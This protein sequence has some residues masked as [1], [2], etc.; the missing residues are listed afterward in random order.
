MAVDAAKASP[1]A[2]EDSIADAD[3][4][5]DVD[6]DSGGGGGAGGDGEGRNTRRSWPWG[7][8]RRRSRLSRS[9]P[10]PPETLVNLRED[11]R[12]SPTAAQ[13]P[14]GEGGGN[15]IVGGEHA[16]ETRTHTPT[17]DGPPSELLFD[18]T[19]REAIAVPPYC[20]VG[21]K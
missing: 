21:V 7:R 19:R 18:T 6:V 1:R 20:V 2:G 16:D 3:A 14:K 13:A 8:L 15:V 10:P 12:E 5:G 4:D 9:S 17:R 11:S